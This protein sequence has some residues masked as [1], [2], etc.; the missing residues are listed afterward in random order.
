MPESAPMGGPSVGEQVVLGGVSAS[1]LTSATSGTAPF[2]YVAHPIAEI[3]V[4]ND[5]RSVPEDDVI[6]CWGRHMRFE[7]LLAPF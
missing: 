3:A 6:D 7:L 2:A 1:L 4:I 5:A